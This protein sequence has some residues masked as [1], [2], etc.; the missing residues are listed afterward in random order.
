MFVWHYCIVLC[1][2]NWTISLQV[3]HF[4]KNIT[5]KPISVQKFIEFGLFGDIISEV[6]ET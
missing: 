3:E 2:K 5:C 6:T 4:A 1:L